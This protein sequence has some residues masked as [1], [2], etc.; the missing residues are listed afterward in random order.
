MI[1][2]F[3]MITLA[4]NIIVASAVARFAPMF[5][6]DVSMLHPQSSEVDTSARAGDHRYSAAG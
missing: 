2:L 1:E 5:A 6:A 4:A 3:T